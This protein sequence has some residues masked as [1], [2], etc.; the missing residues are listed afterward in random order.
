MAV[1]TITAPLPALNNLTLGAAN[2]CAKVVIPQGA[3]KVTLK[4]RLLAAKFAI[5]TALTDG[6]A[7]GASAYVELVADQ[8]FEINLHGLAKTRADTG[9]FYLACA[10]GGVVVEILTEGG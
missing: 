9:A 10:A 4:A 1:T 7:L 6:G 3:A 8:A 5:D 2:V